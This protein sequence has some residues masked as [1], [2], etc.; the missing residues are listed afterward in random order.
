MFL[1]LLSA[2]L[3]LADGPPRL[4]GARLAVPPTIDGLIGE[5]E[6]EGASRAVGFIDP[7]TRRPPLDQTEVWIA[8]D[9]DAIYVAFYSR[10]SRPEEMVARE[11]QAG[12]RF[13]G[14]DAVTFR[15]NPYGTRSW[16]GQSRFSVNLLNTQSEDISGGRAAKREWRGEWQSAVVR[17]PD[18]YTVEMR[19]PW[20]ILPNRSGDA[21]SMDV[22]FERY[23]ARTRIRSMW[24]DTT[25]QGR[26]ELLGYWTGITPPRHVAARKPE[27][28]IYAAPEYDRGEPVF[29]TGLDVRSRLTEQMTGI[30]TISPDFRNIEGQVE[31]IE[32]TRTERFVGETRPF[33]TEG[34]GFFRLTQ[35][36]GFGQ[37]FYPQRIDEFDVGVKAFG[38]PTP[39]LSVGALATFDFGDESAAVARIGQRFGPQAEASLFGTFLDRDGAQHQAFGGVAGARFGSGGFDVEYARERS[40]DGEARD[41]AGAFLHLR[42]PRF[43]GVVNYGWVDPGFRPPLGFVPWRDR[44]GGFLYS[45]YN[46]EFRTGFVRAVSADVVLSEYRTYANEPQENAQR[47]GASILTDGDMRFGLTLDRSRF[48]GQPDRVV[49]GFLVLNESNRFR[50]IGA[51]FSTG[52]RAGQRSQFAA[53]QASY[54]IFRAMDLGLSYAQQEFGDEVN[55]LGILTAAYHLSATRSISGRVVA[56]K[57]AVNAYLAYRSAGGVG[58]DMFVILGDPN[59]AKTTARLSLKFVWAR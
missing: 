22:N 54:R 42:V 30:L 37:M 58:T 24:A 48:F 57:D 32:F 35:G 51:S 36:Y 4:E 13:E 16:E 14:E 44:R 15:I 34:A 20:R 31:G 40:F 18:G 55:R 28:L 49:Q 53:I 39:N 17:Q 47:V 9:D 7:F 2:P 29:R 10:D 43:F 50:R 59:A 27:F 46:T 3:A 25:P 12:A 41:A 8:Y 1:L 21:L 5:A 56:R 19:I 45:E 33:F 23:Q 52:E 38:R 26:S 11:I 6:W